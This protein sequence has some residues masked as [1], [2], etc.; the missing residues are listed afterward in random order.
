MSEGHWSVHLHNLLLLIHYLCCLYQGKP[1]VQGIN[2]MN[3]LGR[4]VRDTYLLNH[5]LKKNSQEI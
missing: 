5:V 2:N 3:K 1:N 4:K